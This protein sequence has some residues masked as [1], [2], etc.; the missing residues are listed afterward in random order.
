MRVLK[1]LLVFAS[2]AALTPGVAVAQT[3]I[4]TPVRASLDGPTLWGGLSSELLVVPT[5]SA[6]V[7]VPVGTAG[8]LHVNLR[9]TAETTIGVT[10]LGAEVLLS[11]GS[12]GLYGAPS[13]ALI[14]GR[15]S[16]WL[17]GS[18]IGYRHQQRERIGFFV[19]GK[20]R[21][22]VLKDAVHSHVAPPRDSRLLPPA[23]SPFPRRA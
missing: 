5:L 20:L 10:A 12:S 3:A 7:R 1:S 13:A 4:P 6:A 2:V 22:L 18:V 8:D 17:A 14:L 19:E 15:S 21:Y 23:T 11:R 9:G 16:G